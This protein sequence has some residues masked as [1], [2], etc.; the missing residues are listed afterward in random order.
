MALCGFKLDLSVKHLYIRNAGNGAFL[1]CT[2][3]TADGDENES[4]P[5]ELKAQAQ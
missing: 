4:E 3:L 5:F 1:K 2:S